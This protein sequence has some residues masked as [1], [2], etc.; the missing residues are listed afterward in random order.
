MLSGWRSR[1][2][3]CGRA[4]HEQH[5]NHQDG[6]GDGEA[7]AQEFVVALEARG[8]G[9]RCRPAWRFAQQQGMDCR[10]IGS[11]HSVRGAAQRIELRLGIFLP[12]RG[13]TVITMAS[14][15]MASIF[16]RKTAFQIGRKAAAAPENRLR[17]LGAPPFDRED[18]DRHIDE[19]E[20]GPDGGEGGGAG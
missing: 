9:G 18:H 13:R 3:T 16:H 20:D 6:P 12:H 5:V 1:A 15:T 10:C 11:S 2:S 7:V 19:R 14:S 8:L 4:H 17:V